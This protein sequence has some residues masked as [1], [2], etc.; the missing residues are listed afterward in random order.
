MIIV[1]SINIREN[2]VAQKAPNKFVTLD[3]ARGIAILMMVFVHAVQLILD[4][5]YLTQDAVIVTQPIAALLVVVVSGSHPAVVPT[6][7]Y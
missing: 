1:A 2:G 7:G 3:V 6:V 4:I 5:Q